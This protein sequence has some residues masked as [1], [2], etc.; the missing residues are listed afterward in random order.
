MPD[1][2]KMFP[3]YLR[4]AGYYTTNN[5]KEDYN[6]IK[7]EGVWDESSKEATWRNRQKG[8]PFF[9][10]FN[11]GHRRAGGMGGLF[12]LYLLL[13]TY[14]ILE[15]SAGGLPRAFGFP[16]IL[17][18]VDGIDRKSE[19]QSGLAAMLGFGI[20]PP[21]GLIALATHTVWRF[22]QIVINNGSWL[23]L[24]RGIINIVVVVLLCLLFITP[25]LLKNSE[26]G[27]IVTLSQA[28]LMPELGQ[29]GRFYL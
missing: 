20:Y 21:A 11:I 8:Q 17:M 16:V 12:A 6:L 14:T 10:V 23:F 13:H 22:T 28:R 1:A 25:T 5:T 15:R 19:R 7:E 2:V 27:K 9:H 18:T 24:R 29:S 26:F 3:V 4:E